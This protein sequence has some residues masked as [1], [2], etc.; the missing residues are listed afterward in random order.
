VASSD[1]PTPTPIPSARI[2]FYIAAA[3]LFAGAAP[4]PYGYYTL[5]RLVAC[6]TFAWAAYMSF[7]RRHAFLPWAYAL[8]ALTF[9]PIVKIYFAKSIWILIDVGAGVFLLA[10]ARL[11]QNRNGATS[12]FEPQTIEQADK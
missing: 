7:E 9:N 1:N 4:L 11:L 3:M 10:T 8:L 2:P 5:L 6:G 12:H